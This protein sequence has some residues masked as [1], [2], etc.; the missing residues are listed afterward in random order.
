MAPQWFLSR[1]GWKAPESD[2]P[3]KRCR[4]LFDQA[5]GEERGPNLADLAG[6]SSTLIA[7]EVYRLL[8]VSPDVETDLDLGDLEDAAVDAELNDTTAPTSE[9]ATLE[10]G[11]E[12]DL[13]DALTA[14]EPGRG[15]YVTRT[16]EAQEFAQ[17]AHMQKLDELLENDQVKSALS[18]F[19][20]FHALLGRDYKVKSDVMIGLPNPDGAPRHVLHAA[21]SSKLTL[22]SDRAQNIRTEFGVLV[23]NRHGRLPHLVVV[24]AEPLPSR[25]VSLTRGTGEIDANYHLLFEAM[26]EA[27]GNLAENE[28]LPRATRAAVEKQAGLW[29]EMV[30]GGRMR[31]YS[32][33]A[34]TLRRT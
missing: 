7:G 12:T 26:D 13:R 16:D 15:W 24:T 4:T 23:R 17:F 20:E 11:L 14:A 31:P 33:L 21:V 5:P 30:D 32:K 29:R 2:G 27:I 8:E 25:L 9:G 3:R 18:D 22:R 28:E 6:T 10:R 1:L 19:P 34:E